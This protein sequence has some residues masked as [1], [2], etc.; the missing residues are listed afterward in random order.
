M[1]A[2][3]PALFKRRKGEKKKINRKTFRVSQIEI[4]LQGLDFPRP[5]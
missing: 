3:A 5:I 1:P 4:I 2:P